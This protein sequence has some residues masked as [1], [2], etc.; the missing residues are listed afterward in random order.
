M[1]DALVSLHVANGL[2]TDSRLSRYKAC[3]MVMDK[4]AIDVRLQARADHVHS[5]FT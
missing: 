3:W 4:G 1:P 2:S 5:V